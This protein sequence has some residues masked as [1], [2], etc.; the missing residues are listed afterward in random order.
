MRWRDCWC[1]SCCSCCT[2]SSCSS[3]PCCCSV[4]GLFDLVLHRFISRSILVRHPKALHLFFWLFFSSKQL[5]I[6]RVHQTTRWALPLIYK[7]GW[8]TPI[9]IG[10]FHPSETRLFSAIY[11]VYFIPF[12]SVEGALSNYPSPPP[13]HLQLLPRVRRRS[14]KQKGRS[15]GRR[16]LRFLEK[17]WRMDE[18]NDEVY[19]RKL[20][21]EST[22]KGGGGNWIIITFGRISFG[23]RGKKKLGLTCN[24]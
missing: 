2:C 19:E 17:L 15:S 13:L 8:N 1:P 3:R 20:G 6:W 24:L 22:Q 12:I 11:R 16:W 10:L 21:S 5:E 14:S 18:K 23:L 9:S 4:G 7:W